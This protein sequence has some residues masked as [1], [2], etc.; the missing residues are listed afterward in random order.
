MKPRDA[1]HHIYDGA[2]V[3]A[4][5]IPTQHAQRSRGERLHPGWQ[6]LGG[7]IVLQQNSAPAAENEA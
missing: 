5:L 4:A 1:A 3:A 6:K 7:G 2:A